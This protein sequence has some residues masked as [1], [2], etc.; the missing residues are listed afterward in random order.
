MGIFLFRAVS[1][2]FVHDVPDRIASATVAGAIWLENATFLWELAFDPATQLAY[3]TRQDMVND[4]DIL[5]TDYLHIPVPQMARL[6]LAAGVVTI[7]IAIGLAWYFHPARPE[8]Q[9]ANAGSA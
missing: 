4:F 6:T 3:L 8:A 1:G 7:V 9:R 5:Q 2:R